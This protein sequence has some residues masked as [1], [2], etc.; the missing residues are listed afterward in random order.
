MRFLNEIIYSN[1][2]AIF[3]LLLLP[4]WFFSYLYIKSFKNTVLRNYF[5]HLKRITFNV[6]KSL[7]RERLSAFFLGTGF[8]FLVIALSGPQFGKKEEQVEQKGVDIVIAL[9]ISKSMDAGDI[10]PSRLKRAK[11]ELSE[12]FSELNG[13]RIGLVTFAGKTVRNSPLTV[14]YYALDMFLQEI[15]TNMIRYQGTD[16]RG[17][18]F[19]SLESFS[20]GNAKGRA[21]IVISDGENHEQ[22]LDGAIEKAKEMNVRIYTIGA[23]SKEGAPIP[24]LGKGF[25]R[26]NN[27]EVIVSRLMPSM[28][29]MMAK[30]SGGAYYASSNQGYQLNSVYQ[31]INTDIE[32]VVISQTKNNNLINRYQVPLLIGLLFILIEYLL[33]RRGRIILSLCLIFP[34]SGHASWFTDNFSQS[35]ENGEFEKSEKIIEQKAIQSQNLNDL[36]NLGASYYKQGKNEEAVEIFKRVKNGG[37]RDQKIKGAFG[38]GNSYFMQSKFKEAIGE[39]ES[40]LNHDPNDDGAKKNLELAKKMLEQQEQKENQQQSDDEKQQQSGDENQQQSDDE[41][42]Q[43]S[44]DEKQQQSDDEKQQQSGDENQQQ[45][46]DENQQQ[47]GD[48]KQQQSGDEK[49]QQSDDKKQQQSGDENQTQQLNDQKNNED[50]KKQSF[51][52][53]MLLNQVEDSRRDYQQQ[54]ENRE[55]RYNSGGDNDW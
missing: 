8:I 33:I 16:L 1:Q 25:K 21:L 12:F 14:D 13:D 47:S 41:K 43:Q 39:Y 22:T 18:I 10:K 42:Q 38:L 31:K 28:L 3:L 27:G 6:K 17:A 44:D 34:F 32:K 48:E 15:D 30:K 51:R 40:V 52:S 7:G 35:Y 4:I 29:K 54:K 37:E 55:P 49:Q 9:D 45:S 24:V 23:G 53:R 11:L 26:N 50:D 19:K 46:D 36:Y 20:D 5:S 2:K